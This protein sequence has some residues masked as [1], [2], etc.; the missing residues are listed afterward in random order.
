MSL[1]N[2]SIIDY[3]IGNLYSVQQAFE[4]CGATVRLA[5]TPRDIELAEKLVLPG[6]GAFADGMLELNRRELTG[7]ILEYAASNRPLL[8]ICLGMQ[9]LATSSEEFKLSHGLDL[10]PGKVKKINTKTA[11]GAELRLPHTGW[12]KI[13]QT[14]L[15]CWDESILNGCK[16]GV[17]VYLVHSYALSTE[18]NSSVLAE[19]SY[20]DNRIA[21]VVRKGNIYGC[22][23]HPEK[24]GLD[25]LKI[26]SNFLTRLS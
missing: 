18:D 26:L 9:M 7:P 11:S 19:C 14:K 23:F 22:Q 25:G 21:T 4:R 15:G 6:V 24:S 12:T 2:V 20:G 1:L 5:R 10:I 16:D 13:Y 17:A 3:G 8:G